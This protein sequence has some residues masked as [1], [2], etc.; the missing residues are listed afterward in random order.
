MKSQPGEAHPPKGRDRQWPWRSIGEALAALETTAPYLESLRSP[1]V[2]YASY[3]RWPE[4]KESGGNRIITE[5]HP[6]LFAVQNR[7]ACLLGP[8]FLMSPL[9]FG[10]VQ[11]GSVKK[12]VLQHKGNT[13]LVHVD[14]HHFFP[15]IFLGRVRATLVGSG[16]S[17]E[18]ATVLAFALT[19]PRAPGPHCSPQNRRRHCP[20]GSPS[21]PLIANMV[22]QPLDAALTLIAHDLGWLFN[23]FGDD[24]FFSS[25][26]GRQEAEVL[27]RAVRAAVRD[28]GFVVREAKTHVMD[29]SALHLRKMLGILV[30]SV[31]IPATALHAHRGRL[32]RI[33][34]VARQTGRDPF[35]DPEM[36]P[37]VNGVLSWA[38][39]YNTD[40][41]RELRLNMA[42]SVKGSPP[43]TQLMWSDLCP[44][45]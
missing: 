13:M 18:Q 4:Q 7:F 28:Q 15:S 27:L 17:Q 40:Q 35:K 9:V 12:C 41:A 16:C 26:Q 29:G 45:Q 14:L 23:R 30:D 25:T 34:E 43:S 1:Q 22:C 33:A 44:C 6:K 10:Y 11:G 31:R 38:E 37:Y 5:P 32:R 42:R 3:N 8:G 21:S 19:T 39:Q 36:A 20:Q 2:A 24:L